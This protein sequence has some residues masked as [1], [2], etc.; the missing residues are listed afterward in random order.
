MKLLWMYD[1]MCIYTVLKLECIDQE[2]ECMMLYGE[3]PSLI[4]E[5]L[6]V[7]L[8]LQNLPLNN[9]LF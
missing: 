8:N 2:F 3:G 1:D 4:V 9:R 5:V 7:T 6:Y